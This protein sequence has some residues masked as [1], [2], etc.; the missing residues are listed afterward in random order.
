MSTEIMEMEQCSDHGHCQKLRDH[1]LV[2]VLD[3]KLVKDRWEE[4]ARY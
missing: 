4:E 2:M 3:M 1:V